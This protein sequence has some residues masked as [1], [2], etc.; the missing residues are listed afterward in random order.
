MM[1]VGVYGKGLSAYWFRWSQNEE[2][3]FREILFSENNPIVFVG[4]IP[5]QLSLAY[6]NRRKM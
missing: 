1:V 3:S 2:G 6:M 4:P 5:S